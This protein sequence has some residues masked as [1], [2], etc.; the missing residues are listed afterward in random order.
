MKR[1]MSSTSVAVLFTGLL[2]FYSC[3]KTNTNSGQN[4]FTWIHAGKTFQP[5]IYAAYLGPGFTFTPFHIIAGFGNFPTGFDMR[6]DFH[7]SSFAVGAYSIVPSPA[8]VNTLYYIDDA[9]YN[10]EG[11]SGTVNITANVNNRLSG[12]FSVT[13]INAAAVTSLVTGS[14]TE[15]TINP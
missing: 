10:L 12:N 14:F 1:L 9:G 15:I 4:S 13:V 5:T 3:K 2:L 6:I 8:T 11:I 7:L